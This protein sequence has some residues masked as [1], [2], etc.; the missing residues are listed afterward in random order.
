M[1]C[2]LCNKDF[3]EKEIEESHD[4]P[5]YLFIGYPNERKNQADKF[6]RHWLCK[7]CHKVYE[8]YLKYNLFCKSVWLAKEFWDGTD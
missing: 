1:K 7:R 8:S 4:I 3:S 2:A 5:V 6:G